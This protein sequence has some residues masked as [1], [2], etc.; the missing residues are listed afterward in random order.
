MNI[1]MNIP[2]NKLEDDWNY[3]TNDELTN[4][5]V[6]YKKLVDDQ[7][8][9]I[10]KI[11][12]QHLNKS[13]LDGNLVGVVYKLL[14]YVKQNHNTDTIELIENFFNIEFIEDIKG[15]GIC[16]DDFLLNGNLV[17]VVYDLLNIV[18]QNPKIDIIELIKNLER[19]KN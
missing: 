15:F 19:Y 5:C 3:Y 11:L 6:G 17:D 13:I 2:M 4:G 8:E 1:P 18:K 7:I 12:V 14:S 9:N 16:L 10:M